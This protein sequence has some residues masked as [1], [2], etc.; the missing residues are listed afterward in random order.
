MQNKMIY[1]ALMAVAI[2]IAYY[3]SALLTNP[4]HLNLISALVFYVPFIGLHLA[5][6]YAI[7]KGNEFGRYAYLVTVIIGYMLFF[8]G[9][10][11]PE[12]QI[13]SEILLLSLNIVVLVILFSK[14]GNKWFKS[15]THP[16]NGTG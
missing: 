3:A 1:I 13:K 14:A 16:S 6:F 11:I 10:P 8:D 2:K 9:E 4:N 12:S 15:L 5:I 7:F